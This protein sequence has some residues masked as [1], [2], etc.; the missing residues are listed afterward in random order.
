MAYR[1]KCKKKK[2][3]RKS[4]KEKFWKVKNE[5]TPGVRCNNKNFML[6]EIKVGSFD[7]WQVKAMRGKWLLT[8]ITFS[9]RYNQTS[10]WGT[11]WPWIG[12]GLLEGS[13]CDTVECFFPWGFSTITSVVSSA[14]AILLSPPP[15]TAGETTECNFAKAILQM[16]KAI[17][18]RF[19]EL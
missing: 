9:I 10:S 8:I 19:S 15:W 18:P 2:K 14:L 1:H 5:A 12:S 3:K 13:P 17:W 11:G 4:I 16:V 6:Y 7:S